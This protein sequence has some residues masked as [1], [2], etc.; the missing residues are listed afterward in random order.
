M[1]QVN[2]MK[3]IGGNL[4]KFSWPD[5]DD[6]SWFSPT[7]IPCNDDQPLSVTSKAFALFQENID[8]INSYLEI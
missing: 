2:C 6:I 3:L 8:L 7:E 4:N 5:K 1:I